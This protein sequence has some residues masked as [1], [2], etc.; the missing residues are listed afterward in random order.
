MG[1]PLEQS[2]ELRPPRRGEVIALAIDATAR[3]Y[4]MNSL[5]LGGDSVVVDTDRPRTVVMWFQAETAD[6]YVH[7]SSSNN[8]NLDPATVVSAGSALAFANA[9]GSVLKYGA[10]AVGYRINRTQ[11]RYLV[12]R[13]STGTATLRFWA[14]SSDGS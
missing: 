11:D 10:Q 8:A 13:T 4:D 7:F 2:A 5:N 14:A 9:H 3:A 6:V 12:V 1:L